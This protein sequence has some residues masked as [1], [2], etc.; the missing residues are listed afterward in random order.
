MQHLEIALDDTE[1]AV[2]ILRG[3]SGPL[4]LTIYRRQ[5]RCQ[6]QIDPIALDVAHEGRH[7]V[8]D[9]EQVGAGRMELHIDVPE[10]ASSAPAV[11]GQIHGLLGSASALD[12]HRRLREQG[13]AS[14]KVSH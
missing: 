5:G 4:G 9:P 10:A 1:S 11:A 6:V 13:P 7:E 3:E 12:R 8:L 14:T 2:G